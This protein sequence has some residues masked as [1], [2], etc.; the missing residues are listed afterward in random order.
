MASEKY[1]QLM[2]EGPFPNQIDPWAEKGHYFHQIHAQMI[3]ILLRVLRKPLQELGYYAGREAS[4]QVMTNLP[5]IPDA[6]VLAEEGRTES[7]LNYSQAAS[8]AEL[9]LGTILEDSLPEIDRLFVRADDTNELVTILEIVSLTNKLEFEDIERYEL[10]RK[11]LLGQGTHCVEIDLSRSV[12]RLIANPIATKFPYHTV[13]HLKTR[14]RR[15]IG[16]SLNEKLTSFALPL[17]SEIVPVELDSIYREAYIEVSIS[18]QMLR[19]NHYTEDNLPFPSLLS[20]DER[21]DLLAKVEAW[22]AALEEA[23]Q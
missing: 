18:K 14:E 6:F 7:N 22:K 11:H 21:K 12:K 1:N 20:E 13:I 23:G 4:L 2:E 19:A 10:R 16:M 15:F 17:R 5:M 3:S 9:V 8:S